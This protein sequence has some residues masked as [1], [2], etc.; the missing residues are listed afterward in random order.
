METS[1][2]YTD[3]E[4]AWISTDERRW[5]NKLMSLEGVTIDRYPEDNDGCLCCRVPVSWIK[6]GP[7]RKVVMTDEQ[8]EA[9]AERMRALRMKLEFDE[10]TEN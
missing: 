6:I 7:P 8:R 9:A 4:T 1:I 2:C 5:I 3:K 10:E